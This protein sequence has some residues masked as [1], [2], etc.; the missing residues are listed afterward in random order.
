MPVRRSRNQAEPPIPERKSNAVVASAQRVRVD[1]AKTLK[2][3]LRKPAAWQE[4]AW[5]Y[6]DE[7]AEL[8]YATLF[9]GNALSKVEFFAACWS[10][11]GEI[12]RVNDEDSPLAGS[13][14]AVQAEAEMARL[15]SARG[16]QGEL[17][18]NMGINL[19][20]PGE[21]YL[22][23][24]GERQ[25]VVR[26][27]SGNEVVT[28]R[29]E[30]WEIRS[31]DEVVQKGSDRDAQGR[32]VILIRTDPEAK[33]T[34][35]DGETVIAFDPDNDTLIRIWQRHPRFSALPDSHL[36][37]ILSDC[38][39][40]VLLTGT[41]KAEAKSRLAAPILTLPSE[42]TFQR[43]DGKP[44]QAGDVDPFLQSIIDTYSTAIEDPQ[45]VLAVAPIL[46]RGPKEYLGADAVRVINLG[47]ITDASTDQRIKDK[48]D[49]LA[50]GLN[51]PVEVLMGHMATTFANAE[52]VDQDTFD[53]H[54][55]PRCMTMADVY[56]TGFL[57]PQLVEAGIAPEEIDQV[58]VWFDASKLIND[59]HLRTAADAMYDRGQIGGAAYR[60]LKGLTEEDAPD[61]NES[62]RMLVERK[63]IFTADL[64]AALL[65][66]VGV[67]VPE[68][69]RAELPMTQDT[70]APVDLN[71]PQIPEGQ[72]PP[73][74]DPEAAAAFLQALVAAASKAGDARPKASSLSDL[75]GRSA[76]STGGLGRALMLLDRDLRARVQGA[77]DAALQRAL[78]RA[79]NRVKG[80]RGTLAASAARALDPAVVCAALGPEMVAEAGF[81]DDE[82]LDGA[83][84][85]LEEQFRDLVSGVNDQ[86]IGM[87][88][89][90]SQRAPRRKVIEQTRARQQQALDAAW[91]W[92]EDAMTAAAKR[93]LYQ[94]VTAAVTDSK[95]LTDRKFEAT[96]FFNKAGSQRLDTVYIDGADSMSRTIAAWMADADT[97]RVSLYELMPDWSRVHLGEF[98][99]PKP[100]Q[101]TI[102]AGGVR[103]GADWL[104]L[105][106]DTLERNIAQ[107]AQAVSALDALQ[108][109]L[110]AQLSRE[111]EALAEMAASIGIPTQ[112][113]REGLQIAGGDDVLA[114]PTHTSAPGMN[115][116]GKEGYGASV[117]TGGPATGPEAEALM[118][119][120]SIFV[121]GYEWSYGP[122]L[123]NKPFD[124]HVFLDGVFFVD[125]EDSALAV[126]PADAWLGISFYYPGDH[127]GCACDF[128]PMVAA[129]SGGADGA[130]VGEDDEQTAEDLPVAGPSDELVQ[131]MREALVRDGGFTIDP[132]TGELVTSGYS[133]A[134]AGQSSITNA[135]VFFD[136]G[137]ADRILDEWMTEHAELF[138]GDDPANIG[139][140]YDREHGEIVL[141]P[142]FNFE[143]RDEA[144]RYAIE[145]DQQAIYDHNFEREIWTGGSGQRDGELGEDGMPR[146]LADTSNWETLS[147]AQ[148]LEITEWLGERG[149]TI[150]EMAQRAEDLYTIAGDLNTKVYDGLDRNA[151]EA[152]TGWYADVAKRIDADAP[153]LFG[154]DNERREMALTGM[155]AAHGTNTAWVQKV[156]GEWVD[157]N[158]LAA[159][160]TATA[161]RDDIEVAISRDMT[162]AWSASKRMP[163]SAERAD[164]LA[165]QSWKL[166]QLDSDVVGRVLTTIV[167]GEGAD[168]I[169]KITSWEN[170]T[171]SV[172]IYRWGVG[173]ARGLSPDAALG[174]QKI[175]NFYNAFISR[176]LVDGA[177]IDR[178]MYDALTGDPNFDMTAAQANPAKLIGKS[179]SEKALQA[180]FNAGWQDGA[181]SYPA[182]EQAIR[183]AA[184][185][186][187]VKMSDMQAIIWYATIV[188]GQGPR[189]PR[190]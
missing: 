66:M 83:W 28:I 185:R 121:Q 126:D 140:W 17:N 190:G 171:K 102:E 35:V 110:T 61:A 21:C 177:V 113:V 74:I 178:H 186:Q 68:L 1:S 62:I 81:T 152:G 4:E 151:I 108:Q 114:H 50:R 143:S 5:A 160:R 80:R 120:H 150:E 58:F 30:T 41:I 135:D 12:I 148:R 168:S 32:P 182:F 18:R 39:A 127:L 7:L 146:D 49:R 34:E 65:R 36:R 122:G 97:N 22:H 16:G 8:K 46:L 124:G 131:Q 179:V 86:V 79:G 9:V 123:R 78:E 60:R 23:G 115:P 162:D 98:W 174:G 167:K 181:G 42:L 20:V 11:E 90:A 153:S 188:L 154:D 172:D 47:R 101:E 149:L 92:Y 45:S 183:I 106:P 187:G 132:T 10:E 129:A 119:K 2:S 13:Q 157:V 145:Q 163:L 156:G 64:T 144:E 63:G 37:G 82:L 52:Q 100:I 130:E 87:I 75:G 112:T 142:S 189:W 14:V 164:A 77:S 159:T 93:A 139:G 170:I 173:D 76:G 103:Y 69:P 94:P 38:E 137:N 91:A 15:R 111:E 67:E 29:P 95:V 125:F 128:I 25:E 141:D 56:E 169:G 96:R 53:D 27:D 133:C 104:P 48:I 31:R 43:A 180:V 70:A 147:D 26:D 88:L 134:P 84:T 19:D 175:R 116:Y 136:D 73:E 85:T 117:G 57:K 6:A 72:P 33:L 109:S 155:V 71:P 165:G 118:A 176:G 138:T 89:S 54:L 3:T 51:L 105:S 59:E 40:L 44:V 99:N 107:A 55:E 161:L 166:S 184:S 24:M 158:Y